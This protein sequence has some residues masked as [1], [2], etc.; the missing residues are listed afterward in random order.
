M[1]LRPHPQDPE[2]AG[3]RD[4]AGAV[5]R[6]AAGCWFAVTLVGQWLFLYYIV[7]RYHAATLSGH[8]ER[9]NTG[10]IPGDTAGNLAFA[11]HVLLAAVVAFGGPLQLIPQ[12]R[13][14][15]I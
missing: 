11:A 6:S 10:Y 3:M 14:R 2:A 7:A 5:L 1:L 13:T 9:W 12:L 4:L 8:P 15:A